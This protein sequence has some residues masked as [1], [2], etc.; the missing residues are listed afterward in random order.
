MAGITAACSGTAPQPSPTAMP[1]PTP[2]PAPT[3]TVCAEGCDFTTIQAAIDAAA[4]GDV[5]E[6]AD[7]VHTEQGIVVSGN[8]TIQ[9]RGVDSTIVQA[10]EAREEASDRVFFVDVGATVVIREM[11]IRHGN[12]SEC[13]MSG[14]GIT[15]HGTL[16]LEY[17]AVV[18]N[19][20]SAGG[21]INN[22]GDLT[23]IGSTISDNVADGTGGQ[24]GRG[25]GSGGGIKNMLGHLV[26][27]D[28]TISGNESA[29][30]GG[31]IHVSCDATLELINSTISGNAAARDGG[32]IRGHGVVSIV[33]STIVGNHANNGGGIFA[34]S[35]MD[36]TGTIIAGN[37]SATSDLAGVSDCVVSE[38]GIIGLNA[39]NLVGDGSCEPDFSGDPL[40]GPLGDN[41]GRT[42]THALLPGSIAIDAIPSGECSLGLDQRGMP[43]S[44]GACDIGAFEASSE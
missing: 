11:T 33:H 19:N 13:P 14:G 44:D 36:F 22:D 2:T 24:A 21:G 9:G 38:G 39:S 26:V 30:G 25:R 10:H 27:I 4:D 17:V 37:T 5:I 3:L 15:N 1:E 42:P 29:W 18:D 8:V 16:T 20:A 40:L 7:P 35:N 23:I 6:V 28:S 32:G 34:R 31:G 43:R 41:G 12:P